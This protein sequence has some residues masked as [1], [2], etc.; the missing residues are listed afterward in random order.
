MVVGS[1]LYGADYE[2]A[3]FVWQ[4]IK[5]LQNHP[6]PFENA[7][8]LGVVRTIGGEPRLIGGIVFNNYRG[9]DIEMHGAFDVPDWCRPTTL[10]RLFAYPFVQLGVTRMTTIT[11]R[12]NKSAR[13]I[14]E[15]VGFK[16]E[17]TVRRGLDGREDAMIYG[18]LRNECKFLPK[19]AN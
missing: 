7:T 9:F 10:R 5:H 6:F 4:R 1:V 14:D 11:G 12:K 15:F 19:D 17:G 13:R 3:Q 8:A 2:V 16:L 18:M